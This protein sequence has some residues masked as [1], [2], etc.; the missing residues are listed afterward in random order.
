MQMGTTA[1]CIPK[2]RLQKLYGQ[3]D[4]KRKRLIDMRNSANWKDLAACRQILLDLDSINS[5]LE[6]QSQR[7]YACEH[8]ISQFP[9]F[10]IPFP[11]NQL[12]KQIY[13]IDA[14]LFSEY[15]CAVLSGKSELQ[16]AK[17]I[18]DLSKFMES[19]TVSFMLFFSPSSQEHLDAK[20]Y[21]VNW[22]AFG[23]LLDVC[24]Y[25][26][27]MGDVQGLDNVF[28]HGILSSN[29]TRL[30]DGDASV[31]NR[32]TSAQFQRYLYFKQLLCHDGK[33][34]AE[35]YTDPSTNKPTAFI[36]SL[37]LA[38]SDGCKRTKI[39]QNS[40]ANL[41][42]I[43]SNRRLFQQEENADF[44]EHWLLSRQFLQD[45]QLYQKSCFKQPE[46]D[47]DDTISN[48]QTEWIEY[49]VVRYHATSDVSVSIP[50]HVH[51]E[52]TQTNQIHE[53]NS[54]SSIHN[55]LL[56]ELELDGYFGAP[57]E[58]IEGYK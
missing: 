38:F 27:E 39:L 23:Y 24:A 47:G 36:P 55:E 33:Q 10:H 9:A 48:G 14:W 1:L 50:Q 31:S 28:S 41:K 29:I 17:A 35:Y 3:L 22:D 45:K 11:A 21:D 13:T 49:E 19:F 42:A 34:F 43:E 4:D 54:T 53:P 20:S 2:S 52:T 18:Q 57:S 16:P 25:L 6:N 46:K 32:M 56:Q 58:S 30:I 40:F 12:A 51:N 7:I 26:F 37:A 5:Q 8:S 15:A 44:I